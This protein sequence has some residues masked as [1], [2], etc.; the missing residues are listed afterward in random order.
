M[1]PD[2]S[3]L[4]DTTAPQGQTK[5]NCVANVRKP[6]GKF[7][8]VGIVLIVVCVCAAVAVVSFIFAKTENKKKKKIFSILSLNFLSQ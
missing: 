4:V 2:F 7:S 6:S 1:D 5:D 8:T 3:V